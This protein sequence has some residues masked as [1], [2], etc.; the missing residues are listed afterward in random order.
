VFPVIT[1]LALGPTQPFPHISNLSLNLLVMLEDQELGVAYARVKIP[2]T[3]PRLVRVTPR[4]ERPRPGEVTFT[5]LEEV[6]AANLQRLFPGTPVTQ[7]YPFRVVR[8]ADVEFANEASPDLLSS[9][10]Q[11][12]R[13]RHFGGVVQ[14]Y[15]D[16]H[17]PAA[18]REVLMRNLD[19]DVQDLYESEGP[20]GLADLMELLL[21]ERPDLKF[22]PL[23]PRVPPSIGR[24]DDIFAAI[25]QQDIL[26][27]HPYESFAPVVDFLRAAASDPDVLAIK[28]TLYRVGSDSPIVRALMT[29][30]ENGKQ[31]AV[32][33]ELRARFEEE[34]NIEWAR[35]LDKAGVH[36]VYGLLGL[37]THSKVA[38]V[39]RKDRDGLRRY[40]HLGTGNYNAT[41]AR[42]YTDF[43]FFTCDDDFG[44][45]ASEFFNSLTGYS[46]QQSYRVFTS[47]PQ[48]LR[49]R[50]HDLIEREIARC[51]Q[52][53]RGQLI[54]KMNALTDPEMIRLLYRASSAGVQVDLLVRGMCTLRPEVAGL[55]ER[56][57]VRSVV[58]RFLEHGRAYYFWNGGSEEAYLSS[59][60]LRPRNLDRRVELFFPIRDPS[61]LRRLRDEILAVELDDTLRAAKLTPR[62]DYVPVAVA[63]GAQRIDSQEQ[64]LRIAPS[65]GSE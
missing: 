52:T 8:D 7:S 29:A 26:L 57:Q 23:V 13:Q 33:V 25:R 32:L 43:S 24:A 34:H 16:R 11:T 60:D 50:L 20:L 44:A 64:F 27:H 45:D 56:I 48:R 61:L 30:R 53:G 51:R 59:A 19:L 47:A 5:W 40:V 36:V 10:E 54:F 15:L 46:R 22:P 65:Y 2:D 49:Q 6:V 9:I 28:Q 4:N 17:T 31:V 58:G 1:P 37:K 55:S 62:G 3:L 12:L 41:T 42:L 38:L 39:V 14:L 21:V 63:D 18:L 35:A